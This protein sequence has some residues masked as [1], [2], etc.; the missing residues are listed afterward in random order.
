MAGYCWKVQQML[1]YKYS[2][3]QLNLPN[4]FIL[5]PPPTLSTVLLRKFAAARR[6]MNAD[7]RSLDAIVCFASNLMVSSCLLVFSLLVC[8]MMIPLDCRSYCSF[9]QLRSGYCTFR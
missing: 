8:C 1:E 3:V 2:K 6:S 7:V 5:D 4:G 9:Y